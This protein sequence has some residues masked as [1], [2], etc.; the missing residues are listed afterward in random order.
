MLQKLPNKKRL[1]KSLSW[2][3]EHGETF[4]EDNPTTEGRLKILKEHLRRP[5]V[6]WKNPILEWEQGQI[7]K[8]RDRECEQGQSA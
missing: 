3:K 8:A 4:T 7:E 1:R 2:Q 6:S 5:E